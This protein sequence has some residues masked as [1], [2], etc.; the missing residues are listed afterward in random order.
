MKGNCQQCGVEHTWSRNSKGMYCSIKC[1]RSSEFDSQVK[2]WL[3]EGILPQ[4]SR[5]P[6]K[7]L[8]TLNDSCW[9]C[10]IN[11]WLGQPITLELEHSDGDA[12]NNNIDNLKL[13]C[14]NC[15]SQTP[16]YKN[17]NKGNGRLARR[18]RAIQDYHKARP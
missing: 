7:Y 13:L 17:K 12:T 18:Q 11:E 4:H 5:V 15:H 2:L 6:R 9:Q 3:E 14:P 1:Q 10:G 8:L 16:T